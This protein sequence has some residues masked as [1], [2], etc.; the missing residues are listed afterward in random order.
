MHDPPGADAFQRTRR[1]LKSVSKHVRSF[2]R[3][4][5]LF[6]FSAQLLLSFT[7]RKRGRP[8]RAA[9]ARLRGGGRWG[10]A[11]T[12]VALNL[13]CG[14]AS[15]VWAAGWKGSL[16]KGACQSLRAYS[17]QHAV[18]G[19]RR[20]GPSHPSASAA[21]GQGQVTSRRRS[22]GRRPPET[23][24]R[25]G[26][27]GARHVPGLGLRQG[28]APGLRAGPVGTEATCSLLTLW[29]AAAPSTCSSQMAFRSRTGSRRRPLLCMQSPQVAPATPA[30]PR[31]VPSL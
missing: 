19:H 16:E 5:H 28:R 6:K 22:G 26:A 4:K 18:R 31:R 27:R 14:P 29:A 25:R 15:L 3:I 7:L 21:V 9:G 10:V 23:S 30:R 20:L 1:A 17:G 2:P 11:L 24:F 12:G 8:S 13:F